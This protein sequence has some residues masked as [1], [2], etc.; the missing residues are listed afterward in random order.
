MAA[1][2]HGQMV[3]LGVTKRSPAGRRGPR[4]RCRI[5]ETYGEEPYLV[6]TMATA[7]VRG[8]GATTP[9]IP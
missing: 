3:A 8:V 5:E 9:T 6:G 2:I 7:F 1:A 4:P